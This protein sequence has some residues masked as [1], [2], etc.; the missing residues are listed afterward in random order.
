MEPGRLHGKGLRDRPA[1]RPRRRRLAIATIATAA[2]AP[3]LGHGWQR[4]P[5]PAR[6]RPPEAE[7][8]EHV[9]Q[10]RALHVLGRGVVLR[11]VARQLAAAVPSRLKHLRRRGAERREAGRGP[12]GWAVRR[13][14]SGVEVRW[15]G[16]AA[17]MEQRGGQAAA[18]V[19]AGKCTATMAPRHAYKNRKAAAPTSPSTPSGALTAR[20]A[21]R[22]APRPPSLAPSS[23]CR[24]LPASLCPPSPGPWQLP[25]RP[26]PHARA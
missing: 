6:G 5:C 22:S 2:P 20:G 18:K 1:R 24:P 10:R 8:F 13:G 21:P 4:A 14:K 17:G 19:V 9:G 23:S 25:G 12:V 11:Q 15:S 26:P 3:S 16:G 7:P